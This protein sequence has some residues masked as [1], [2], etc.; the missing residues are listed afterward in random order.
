M[1]AI[2]K[3]MKK[4][5]PAR[6]ASAKAPISKGVVKP[7]QPSGFPAQTQDSYKKPSRPM[8]AGGKYPK[9]KKK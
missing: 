7:A 5:M 6:K 1:K 2:S 9:F 3:P 4:I 8:P